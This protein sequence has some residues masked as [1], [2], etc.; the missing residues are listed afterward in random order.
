[1]P[2]PIDRSGTARG[3]ILHYELRE[4]QSGSVGVEYE[5]AIDEFYGDPTPDEWN[6]WTG[7]AC[8]V[9]GRT[10]LVKKDGSPNETGVK[11]LVEAAGWIPGDFEQIACGAWNPP[12]IQVTIKADEYQGEV[13]YKAEWIN[14]YDALVGGRG[15]DAA[16]AKALAAKYGSKI[17]AVAGNVKRNEAVPPQGKPTMP[18]PA[19]VPDDGAENP[20]IPF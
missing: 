8:G 2:T 16:T 1:M 4:Y 12:P 5:L 13:R 6:D 7:Y 18:K 3:R 10:I 11:S 14:P 20:D 17:R 9:Y 15:V 19:T